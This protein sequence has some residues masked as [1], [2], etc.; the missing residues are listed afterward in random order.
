MLNLL[1][2]ALFPAVKTVTPLTKTA[3]ERCHGLVRG[4]VDQPSAQTKMWE[5]QQHLL[6]YIVDVGDILLKKHI[7]KL[8]RRMTNFY[9][10]KP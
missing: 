3:E 5:Y 6:H 2:N 1:S 10:L 4:H 8:I 7:H 9:I